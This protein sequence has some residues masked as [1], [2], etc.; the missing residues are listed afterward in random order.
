MKQAPQLKLCFNGDGR[1]LDPT[2]SL[3]CRQC[4]AAFDAAF[5][6]LWIKKHPRSV[7]ATAV[8]V[9]TA[10]GGLPR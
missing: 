7:P 4:Q 3:L 1:K 5:V 6:A 2:S 9:P 10:R 8:T